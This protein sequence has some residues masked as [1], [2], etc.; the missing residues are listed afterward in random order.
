MCTAD[1]LSKQ[2]DHPDSM[3]QSCPL[4]DTYSER[5]NDPKKKRWTGRTNAKDAEP[6][7]IAPVDVRKCQNAGDDA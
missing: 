7:K 3:L 1:S 6:K 5:N 4:P 2:T